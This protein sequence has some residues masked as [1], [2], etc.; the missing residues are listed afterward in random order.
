MFVLLH[1]CAL[2]AW[3][4]PPY[5]GMIANSPH[6]DSPARRLEQRLFAALSNAGGETRSFLTANYIDFLGAHQYWDFFAPETPRIHRYLEVCSEILESSDE[7][8]I[9]CI[10]PLYRSFDGEIDQA[11]HPHHGKRSR[12]FR[13]VENLYRLHRPDLL[14]AFTLYWRHKGSSDLIRASR[15]VGAHRQNQSMKATDFV[16][17]GE[18]AFCRSGSEQS[19]DGFCSE[20][21]KNHSEQTGKSFLL[22]HEFTLRPGGRN[23]ESTNARRDELI[24]IA[25]E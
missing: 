21:T 23:C 20:F 17:S 14:N 16:G 10:N 18:I 4:I 6:A 12:S 7:R 3:I 2:V 25:P 19:Q 8:R 15:G 1:F 22:L 5:S 13:L 9:Q 24:W 11:T